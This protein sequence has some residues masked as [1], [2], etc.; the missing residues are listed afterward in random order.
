[1]NIA[2]DVGLSEVLL[3]AVVALVVLGPKDLPRL[4]NMAGKMAA[5]ARRLA[6]EFQAAFNQMAREAEMEEMRKEIEALKRDNVFEDARRTIEDSVKP[7]DSALRTEAQELQDAM[8]K[9]LDAPA[10]DAGAEAQGAV[11]AG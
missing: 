2:P 9:P 1:M 10:P 5:Q 3:I 7:V 11:K 8:R 6:G 4:M